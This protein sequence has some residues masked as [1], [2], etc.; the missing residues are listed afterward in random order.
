[1]SR[2]RITK[3]T[4][5]RKPALPHALM[6]AALLGMGLLAPVTAPRCQDLGFH[7]YADARILDGPSERSWI[8]GGFG[9]LRGGA[10]GA[11]VQ[12]AGAVQAVAQLSPAVL[13]TGTLQWDQQDGSGLEVQEAYLRYRPVSTTPNRW[14]LRLGSFFPPLSLENDGP[15]W[16]SPYT[17]TPSAI[18]SWV[19]EE[20]RTTG[21]DW[22]VEHRMHGGF[23]AG[24]VGA[25]IGND[26]AGELMAAR[27]WSLSDRVYGLN[28]LIR[29][30]DAAARDAPPPRR[31]DPFVEVDDRVGFFLHA[32][33]HG[34]G[35]GSLR[36][37][38]YDNRADPSSSYTERG[39]RIFSWHTRFGGLGA[40]LFRDEWRWMAQLMYGDTEFEPSEQFY[41]TTRFWSGYLLCA[42]EYGRWRPAV[43]LDVFGT[44]EQ[45]SND[46]PAQ[47]EH[48]RA[49]TL[50]LNWRPQPDWR[51][52]AEWLAV[53]SSRTSRRELGF[54]ERQRDYQVQLS[55][56]RL[57]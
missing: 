24:G 42:R 43:R 2:D 53:D 31:F 23:W 37:L 51:L 28:A 20:V 48:G 10:G 55:V 35:G 21:I 16:T 7:G 56:R 13:A 47:N 9:K 4:A 50:A 45:P 36:L 46:S 54:G 33:A 25:F 22:R 41:S 1:M 12:F 15:G 14:S 17:L 34:R 39:H 52:S 6:R 3:T 40:D 29:E 32:S 19:G 5:M 44:D 18:N 27:G 57:F 30:P 11:P 49:L 8:E 38:Y 26:P